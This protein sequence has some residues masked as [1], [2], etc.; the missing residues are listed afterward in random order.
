MGSPVSVCTLIG[1]YTHTIT[2]TPCAKIKK[3][4][5]PEEFEAECDKSPAYKLSYI[6][7]TGLT[8][9]HKAAKLG[10]HRLI[11]YIFRKRIGAKILMSVGDF[12]GR[13]PLFT[14]IEFNQ[15]SVVKMLIDFRANVNVGCFDYAFDPIVTNDKCAYKTPLSFAVQPFLET[16]LTMYPKEVQKAQKVAM[17]KLLLINGAVIVGPAINEEGRQVVHQARKEINETRSSLIEK[18]SAATKS[19]MSLETVK[20]IIGYVPLDEIPETVPELPAHEWIARD[21]LFVNGSWVIS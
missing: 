5:T 6:G 18:V 14:A 10:N 21:F 13:T 17:V 4:T 1:N 16:S 11:E 19:V 3:N 12:W 15:R 9:L 20:T 2:A 8:A 7:H